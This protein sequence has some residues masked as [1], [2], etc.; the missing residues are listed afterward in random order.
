MKIHNSSKT[1]IV[2]K[3]KLRHSPGRPSRSDF[4]QFRFAVHPVYASSAVFMKFCFGVRLSRR[5]SP[6][7]KNGHGPDLGSARSDNAASIRIHILFF[8][9]KW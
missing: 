8:L 4:V 3:V 5:V 6:G 9:S 7:L 1:L 2:T